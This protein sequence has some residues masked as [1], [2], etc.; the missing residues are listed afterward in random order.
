MTQTFFIVFSV[1]TKQYWSQSFY[2]KSQLILV[3]I[4][5]N[6]T[7]DFLTLLLPLVCIDFLLGRKFCYLVF[8]FLYAHNGGCASDPSPIYLVIVEAPDAFRAKK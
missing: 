1:I 3:E 7:V 5:Q 2:N 4:K 8:R 6:N